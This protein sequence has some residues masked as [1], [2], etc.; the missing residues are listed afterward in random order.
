MFA[1]VRQKAYGHTLGRLFSPVKLS[2]ER[3][4]YYLPRLSC[5]HGLFC[6]SVPG[7]ILSAAVPT[8]S[9]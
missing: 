4:N 9:E 1:A 8:L 5:F 6:V 2:A 7:Q 3:R